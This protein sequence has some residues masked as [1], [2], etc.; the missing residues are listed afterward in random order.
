MGVIR[1]GSLR[2]F[3]TIGNEIS[4]YRVG[5]GIRRTVH[6]MFRNVPFRVSEIVVNFLLNVPVSS[7]QVHGRGKRIPFSVR[8]RF[9]SQKKREKKRGDDE[10]KRNYGLKDFDLERL[11]LV[12]SRAERTAR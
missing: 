8:P 1:Y 3:T 4:P 12:A 5:A 2:V 7:C 11:L 6:R 9:S 10:T